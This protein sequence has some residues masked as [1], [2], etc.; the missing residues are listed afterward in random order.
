MPK[1]VQAASHCIFISG[2]VENVPLLFD[3]LEEIKPVAEKT[4]EVLGRK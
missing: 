4:L 1:N 2:L 3:T